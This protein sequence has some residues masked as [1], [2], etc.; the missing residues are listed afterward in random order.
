MK[1]LG[2]IPFLK[3][4]NKIKEFSL[5]GVGTM[6]NIITNFFKSIVKL[7]VLAILIGG[8]IG[9]I[10]SNRIVT[11]SVHPENAHDAVN[12]AMK[13]IERDVHDLIES[14]NGN[15]GHFYLRDQNKLE[16]KT[17]SNQ[18]RNGRNRSRRM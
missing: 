5:S 7:F 17:I 8:L 12:K 14:Y 10:C 1:S 3:D 11:I 15:N 9:F 4:L 18:N 16:V 13:N 6:E 2:D